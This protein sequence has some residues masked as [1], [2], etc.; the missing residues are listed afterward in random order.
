[1]CGIGG[2]LRYDDRAADCDAVRRMLPCLE[3]RG[4]D[5]EGLWQRGPIAFGHRRLKIIDLS[6]SGA[7]PMTD[8]Q[9]GLTLVFNGCIYN[10]RQLREELRGYGYRFTSTSDTEVILKAYH[11]WGA[12][13]VRRLLGMFAFAVAEHATGTV[14]LARDRLGIKPMYLAETPGRLRFASTLPA[15]LAAR[16]RRHVDR[17]GGATA[18]HDVPLGGPGAAHAGR[19]HPQLPPTTVRIIKADGTS[20]SDVYWEASHTRT[21]TRS[22]DRVGRGR[23]RRAAHRRRAADGRRRAGRGAALRRAGLQLHRG[24]A[25]RAGPA[26]PEHVQHRL[27]VGGW[28]ERRRVR[29]FGPHRQAVRHR[30]PPD[31]DRPGPLPARGGAHGRGDE[32]ADGQPRLH[33]LQP[34][35]RGRV[36][37]G[38]G[39]PVGTGRGRDPG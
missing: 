3:S 19:R 8:E 11:R 24:P 27:R 16:R 13:C 31:P 7:Q 12:G 21:G 29:L 17:Q 18:L 32:R 34:A 26:R 25:R 15:L 4:P 9:L 1:M 37:A 28:G 2:E 30:P 23:A 36:A 10:Y 35:Q 14:M 38:H 20:T 22:L 39:R 5:G 6:E 33:R